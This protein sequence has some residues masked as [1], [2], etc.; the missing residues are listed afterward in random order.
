MCAHHL[1][2]FRTQQNTMSWWKVVIVGQLH[3]KKPL[4]SKGKEN[5]P[6]RTTINEI[7]ENGK[8]CNAV[9]EIDHLRSKLLSFIYHTTY[10]K[11]ILTKIMEHELV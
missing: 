2:T 3:T 11:I 7:V 5:Q 4:V 8:Q 6:R 10:L 1:N 9:V